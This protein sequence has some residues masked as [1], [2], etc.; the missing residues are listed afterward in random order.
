MS[1]RLNGALAA[2]ALSSCAVEPDALVLPTVA[3]DPSLPAIEL[4][5][6]RFYI[7]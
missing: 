1:S 3:E 4:G 5:D 6:A 2:L 7:E